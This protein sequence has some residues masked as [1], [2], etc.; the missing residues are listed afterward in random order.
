MPLQILIALQNFNDPSDSQCPTETMTG[1]PC[2][3]V[4]GK[5]LASPYGK[6]VITRG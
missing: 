2:N 3:N 6:I 4:N 1:L 5:A